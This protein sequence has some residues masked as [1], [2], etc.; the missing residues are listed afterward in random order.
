MTKA[1]V[2][3]A[4]FAL[5]LA[6]LVQGHA[7]PDPLN[8]DQHLLADDTSDAYSAYDGFDLQDLYVREG[9]FD[10]QDGLVFR[11][12]IYGGFSPAKIASQLHLDMAITAAGTDSTF[13]ISSSDGLAWDGDGKV[14]ESS[15]EAE[16]D[17]AIAGALQWFIPLADLGV[18][19]NDT[20]GP[21]VWKNFADA[22]LRDIAP[23][24]TPIP[25]TNGA[26]E[27]PETA[28]GPS[29]VKKETITLQGT[30]GYTA[31]SV[32]RAG[33]TYEVAVENLITPIG[34]HIMLVLPDAAGWTIDRVDTNAKVVEVGQHPTFVFT[35]KADSTAKPFQIEVVTDL[36]GREVLTITPTAAPGE[37]PVEDGGA[38]NETPGEDSPVGLWLAPL[39]LAAAF[40]QKRR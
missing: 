26:A 12:V 30:G 2:A 16:D 24:G 13:R 5:L 11:M 40:V 38:G 9:H 21:F 32:K 20:V 33:E 37:A 25:G 8:V 28:T 31:T 22:D 19:R 27:L 7:S 36:G 29:T 18:G 1:L 15:L 4:A 23:G 35:G 3:V 39:A 14:L 10:D 34:Q 17:G 6:P